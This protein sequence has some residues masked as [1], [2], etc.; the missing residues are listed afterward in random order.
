MASRSILSIPDFDVGATTSAPSNS[1]DYV[2][3]YGELTDS[4]TY[5]NQ[6]GGSTTAATMTAS[7]IDVTG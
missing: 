2:T 4:R 1:Y 5:E 3:I 6:F 7:I